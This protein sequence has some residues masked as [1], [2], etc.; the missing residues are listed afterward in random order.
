MKKLFED[1]WCCLQC[2]QC[3]WFKVGAD[4]TPSTCKRID[5]KH[6]KFAFLGSNHMIVDSLHLLSVRTL[7][8]QTPALG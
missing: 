7:N 3:K 1:E 8:L 6:I 2:G 4:R 5:H